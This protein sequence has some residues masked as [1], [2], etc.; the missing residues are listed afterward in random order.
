MEK[1]NISDAKKVM[2]AGKAT[3]TFLSVI[4]QTRFTFKIIRF[5]DKKENPMPEN[6]RPLAVKVLTGSNNESDYS[7]IGYIFNN[8][9]FMHDKKSNISGNAKSVNAFSYVFQNI[10]R[11]LE[12]T[13]LEI[14]HS[15]QCCRCGRLLTDPESIKSGLGPECIKIAGKLI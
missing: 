5:R 9:L 6:K 10:I 11:E 4:T 15:G 12:N 2:F 1:M 13:N 7:K 3:L 14:Y 8:S